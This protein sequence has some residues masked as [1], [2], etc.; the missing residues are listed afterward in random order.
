MGNITPTPAQQEDEYLYTTL[1][2]VEKEGYY[3]ATAQLAPYMLRGKV[4]KTI[5]CYVSRSAS[6]AKKVALKILYKYA[7]RTPTKDTQV[8][9]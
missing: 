6:D 4:F 8:C 2:D 9:L 5:P 3:Q 1:K 7:V